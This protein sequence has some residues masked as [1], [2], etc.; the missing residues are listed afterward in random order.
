MNDNPHNQSP[1][2][3]PRRRRIR[4]RYG[5]TVKV[6]KK[7]GE[8]IHAGTDNLEFTLYIKYV[9]GQQRS[10]RALD[11]M[12]RWAAAHPKERR[13]DI[14][15]W[16][17]S[18]KDL[19]TFCADIDRGIFTAFYEQ[20]ISRKARYSRLQRGKKKGQRRGARSD[21]E[22]KALL[23]TVEHVYGPEGAKMFVEQ[24]L[25]TTKRKTKP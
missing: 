16:L 19:P 23:S 8:P 4:D 13:E 17:E 24:A 5:R 7:T 22:R 3:A 14:E 10:D 12:K 25:Q 18:E 2:A 1:G 9:T 11:W 21:K 6:D 15:T 20:E